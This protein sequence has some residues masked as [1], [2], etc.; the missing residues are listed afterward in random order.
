[1]SIRSRHARL[2]SKSRKRRSPSPDR[3]GQRKLLLE[4]LEERQLLAVGPRLA[5]VQ[6]NNSDLFSFDDQ[7][8]NVRDV[9]PREVALRFDENQQID[10][11][12]LGAIRVT[13]S[14]FDGVFG[15]ANDK[16]I[17]PGF[18]GVGDS[19]D[20]NEVIIRFAETLPDDVYRIEVFGAGSPTPL[21]NLRGEAFIPTLNDG[22]AD[23]TRDTIR[24]ELD[25]GPQ[26]I[27]V[28]PQPIS[29]NEQ[30]SL[31][32]ERNQIEVY[33]NNDDL[34]IESDDLGNPTPSSAENPEFYQLIF[35]R[36][37]VRNTDDVVIMPTN[38]QYDPQRDMV[39]LEYAQDLDQLLHPDT[40]ELIGPGTFRLRIG[41]DEAAPLPPLQFSP[42][43][44]VS[45]S[46]N[47]NDQVVLQ[48]TAA[49]P[50][51]N[52][53][54][55]L[56]ERHD[57][58]SAAD[59]P[60]AP[61][62]RVSV[63][64][65]SVL[66]DLNSHAGEEATAAD[67]V[68]AVNAHPEARRLI[69]AS[70][71]QGSP[72]TKVGDREVNYSPLHLDGLGSS[73][74]TATEL[75]DNTDL[76]PVIV[77]TGS[78]NAFV[79]GQFFEITDLLG[80]TRKFEFDSDVPSAL[81]D[82][83]SIPVAFDVN[84]SQ[85][86]VGAS[87]VAAINGSSFGVRAAL[88]GNR[89][90]LEGDAFVN[91]GDGVAGLAKDFQ[92]RFDS[93]PLLAISRA[94]DSFAEGQ[95]FSITDVNGVTQLFE[96]D[97]GAT[98]NVPADLA[99]TIADMQ[100]FT[101]EDGGGAAVTFELEDTL[102]G[103]GTTMPNVTIAYDSSVTT[104]QQ[105]TN[106]II[107]AIEA[108]TAA[109]NLS[110]IVPRDFG[111]GQ[112]HLGSSITSIDTSMT[113][114]FTTGAAGAQLDGAI[115][116]PFIPDGS[117][118]S[119]EIA[120][121]IAVAVSSAPFDVTALPI[122]S[123]V[124]FDNDKF[125]D[126]ALDGID[127]SLQ[128]RFD[129]G[130]V[131]TV[132]KPGSGF[133]DSDTITIRDDRG[134][135]RTF[136]FDT[137]R[138]LQVP[139]DGGTRIGDGD[140][141]AVM[142]RLAPGATPT[143]VMV[144]EFERDADGVAAGNIPIAFTSVDSQQVI[145]DAILDAIQMQLDEGRLQGITLRDAGNGRLQI[146]SSPA[147]HFDV[148]GATVLSLT[149]PI[150]NDP[151]A[152]AIT[153]T[154]TETVAEMAERIADAVNFTDFQT[155]ATVVADRIYLTNDRQVDL[156]RN[157]DAVTKTSQGIIVSSAI[158]PQP[159]D[160][161]FPGANDE[162][163][164]RDI[165]EEIGSGVEQHINTDFG[166]N[167]RDVTPGVTT[168]FYNFRDDYGVDQQGI[169]LSNAITEQQRQRAREAF[170]LW[171][172]YLGVQ[173]LESA[174]E[175]ITVVTGDLNALNPAF[176]SV[177]DFA[178][179]DFR[180][181]I[182]PRFA[183][184]L[185]V[186]DSA[187][188]WNEDFGQDW[189]LNTMVGIG[190]M[191]G[192]D[193][194]ND[195]PTSNLMARFTAPN[196]PITG[197]QSPFFNVGD[198][199]PIYPGNADILHG[200]H[201]YRPDGVDI[202]LYRFAIDLD[203]GRMGQF[204]AETFAERLPN[205]SL[206][207][208]VVRLY[209]ENPDGTRVL[210]AQNDDY[211][212]RDS[213]IEL[214]LGP[215]IYYIGVSAG[216][217]A[218][219]DPTIED[220]GIG[221]T[222]QG[223]YDL[224]LNFRSQVEDE[225]TIRDAGGLKTALDGDADGLTGGVYN[226]WFQ[227]RALNRV[228]EVTD[229]GASYRDGQILTITNAQG[230]VRRFEFDSN[231]VIAGGNIRVPF[232]ASPATSASALASTLAA[233]I[234]SVPG[235]NVTATVSPPG[236]SAIQLAGERSLSLST[237]FVGIDIQGKTIFVDKTAGPNADGSL[238][239]P[240]NNIAANGVPN[241]FAATHPGDIVR[242]VGNGGSDGNVDTLDDNFAYE[243]GFGTLPG[244]L[245]T[246]GTDMPVPKGTTVMIDPGAIFKMRRSRIGVGSSSLT[247]DRG[248]GALQVLGTPERNVIF[249]SWLD[250]SIG[251][252]NHPPTTTP[253][254]GD[255]GGLVFRAD[256]DNAESRPNL[257]DQGIFLNYVNHADIRY[258][259]GGSVVIDSI[260]QIVN[261]IQLIQTRPT[262]SYNRITE[263]ADSAMSASPNSF[264]ET[265]FHSP[266]FQSAGAF[267]S[268][269]S[270]IGPSIHS[271]TLI[272]NSTNG[273]FIRIVTPAGD[274]LR[275]LVVSGRFDD[276]DIVHVLSENLVIEGS[277][278]DPLLD[279]ER[280][281]VQLITFTPRSGGDLPAGTYS[282]KITFVDDNGFEGRPSTAST[283]FT[284]TPAA[285]LA[286]TGAIQLNQLP[287]V[288]EGFVRRRIYRTDGLSDGVYRL[289]ADVNA[290][291]TVFLD[292][293]APGDLRDVLLRD[294]PSAVDV[295]LAGQARG[296]LAKGIYNYRVVYVD[297][298][299]REGASSDPTTNISIA[300]VGSEGGV[301]LDNLPAA[302]GRFVAKRIYRSTVG[303]ISPYTLVTE[304]NATETTYVDD[305][306]S[307][308]GTLDA[309]AFGVVRA[310]PHA[311]LAIDPGTVVKLE[312]A[313]LDLRFGA[314]LI[315]EGRVGQEVIFTSRLDDEFGAGGT[316][317]TNDDDGQISGEASPG[318]GDWGGIFFGQLSR[319][320]IDN[321]LIAY[322][323][324]INRIEGT[325]T[326][327]NVI[328]VH[329]ADF[330]L[331]NSVI[332]NNAEG[333]GGQ[334]PIDRFGRGYN[335]PATI[336]VRGA[337]PVIVDNVFRD[338]NTLYDPTK[339]SESLQSPV[340]TINANSLIHDNLVDFG[341]STGPVDLITRY[342][343]NAGPLVRGN[344]LSNNA[345]NAMVI[346]G[347]VLT[348]Q[349]VW[350][351]TDIVHVL[352]NQFDQ[353]D[354]RTEDGNG[355]RTFAF[356]EVVIPEHHTFGGL[357]L[358]SSPNES[359][360][361]KLRGSGR[362]DN[363]INQIQNQVTVGTSHAN[364]Y[365][366]AG[367]TV[368]G[369]LFETDDRIGGTLH[370]IGQPGFPVVM[371]SLNDD[372]VGAGVQP[373]GQSQIDT[374]NNGLATIPRP[375]D[376]RGVRLDQNSN[377][378]NVEII[379][380]MEPPDATAPGLNA[381]TDTAQVLGDL[382]QDEQSGDENLRMGFEIQGFINE[383]ND[384]DVYSFGAVAG[385]EIWVDIDRTTYTLDTIIELLD[386]N[387][388]VLAR[389]DDTIRE[390]DEVDFVSDQISSNLIGTLQKSPSPYYP[391]HASGLPR[392]YYTVNPR[393]A[394]MRI[395]LPGN[396]GTRSTYHL[397]V[398]SKDGLTTGIYQLQV[399]S[400]EF[401]EF[402]GSTVRF[403]SISYANNGIEVIG[404]PKHSPLTGE[405]AE[406]ESAGSFASNDSFTP[407]IIIPG[408]QPQN[409]G[410]LL[411]S[412]R[413][414]ISIAGTTASAG[415]ID[416]YQFDVTY[417]AISDPSQHH[418][419]T[420]F[421]VDYADA[422]VRFNST[423][424]VF[425]AAGRLILIGRDSN[426]AEDRSGPLEG[427]DL[428]DLT[429][430]S[431][432][433]R[434]PFIGPVELPQ[435]QYFVA[436]SSNGRMPT[437]LLNNP[438]LRLEPVNSVVRIADDH[439]GTFGGS[440]AADPVN[441]VLLDPG[442]VGMGP[443]RWHVTTDRSGDPGH[444]L[445]TAFDR[446]RGGVGG[447][448]AGGSL[449][450]IEPNDSLAAAQNVDGG[451]WNTTFDPNIGDNLMNTSTTI[452]HLTINGSGDGSFDYYSFNVTGASALNPVTAIFDVDF[453]FTT[454]GPDS[455]DAELFLFDP[456]GNLIT[457]NDDAST[458][459]GAGGST[460]VLD[461]YIETLLTQSGTYVI[462]VGQFPSSAASTS[463]ITGSPLDPGQLYT[464]QISL[465][466]HGTGGGSTFNGGQS[467]Y[468]GDSTAGNTVPAG[469]TG[470]LE[471]NTFSLQGYSAE[472]LP[473]LYFN[474][475]LQNSAGA[476][477]FRVRVVDADT[478]MGPAD[479]GTLVASSNTIDA[480]SPDVQLIPQSVGSWRQL[481]LSLGEFAGQ[482]NLQ[483][484][485]EYT[486]G[487][488]GSEEGV[489]ID[490]LIIGFAERGEMVT[491]SGFTAATFST[492]PNAPGNEIHTGDYQLEIRKA[493]PFGTSVNNA[494][495][496][497]VLTDSIDTN[498]RETQATTLVVPDGSQ[499]VNGQ[500]FV[501]SDG[502]NQ[503]TFE[504]EDAEIGDGVTAGNVEIRYRTFNS[505]SGMWEYDADF[506]IA[507]R[508]RDA[509]NSAQVQTILALRAAM[510]DGEVSGTV[511]TDNRVNLF[512]TAL[513]DQPK[514]FEVIAA[515]SDANQLRDT[516]LGSGVQPVGNAT[517]VGS[518]VSAGRFEGGL[519]TI[520][521]EAGILL[522]TGD[523]RIADDPNT[524]DSSTARASQTGDA[525]L[526]NALMM[527]AA[528]D[529]RDTT[530]LEFDFQVN[531]GV[532]GDF[533][534]NFLFASEEYNEQVDTAFNDAVAILI[535]RDITDGI[536][537][538]NVALVPGP[539][540]QAPVSLS[541]V[542]NSVNSGLFN[543][544]DPSDAGRF[545]DRFAYDGFTEVFTAELSGA[546][547]LGPG[548][549][550]IKIV[551]SDVADLS[552]DSAIFVEAG[553]MATSAFVRP[554]EGIP[555]IRHQGQG[556][557]NRFR[558]QG[559]VII[560]S[561]TIA[562]SKTFGVVA[563]AGQR[564]TDGTFSASTAS[565]PVRLQ[566][567]DPGPVR[568]LVIQNNTPL[569]GGFAPGVTIANNTIF[570]DGSLGGIHVSGNGQTYELTTRRSWETA[571]S[572]TA[573]DSVCD[574]D[575][576]RITAFG[577]VVEFEF[578]DVAG[579]P[580]DD[581]NRA[582]RVGSGTNGG[583]GWAEGRVPVYFRRTVPNVAGY[584]QLEMA[585]AI[586]NAIDGSRLVSND[587]RLSINTY[588]APS[589]G[590]GGINIRGLDFQ[591]P[592]TETDWAVYV[593]S[594]T[595]VVGNTGSESVT[596]GKGLH[597][598]RQVGH[599]N[600]PQP[601]ARV[602]NNTIFGDDGSFA[603]FPDPNVEPNDTLFNAIETR[604][605]RQHNPVSYTTTAT[606]G[607]SQNFLGDTS[608]D[609][610][611]YQFQLDIGD[612]VEID[613]NPSI[614]GSQL[615]P[616]MRLFNSVGEELLISTSPPASPQTVN[617]TATAGGTY[618]VAVSGAGNETYSS[619]SLASR[620]G[621]ASTGDYSLSVNV[622][623]P[624]TYVIQ[625]Q[626]GSTLSGTV[627]LEI[628]DVNGTI[629][630]AT[631]NI[632]GGDRFPAVANSIAN[633]I[634][635]ATGGTNVQNLPNGAFGTANPLQRIE[636]EVYGDAS[637]VFHNTRQ[638]LLNNAFLVPDHE[639]FVVIR[640]AARVTSLNSALRITPIAD[641]DL[642]QI[643]VERGILVSNEAT[644]TLLNNVLANLHIGVEQALFQPG[645]PGPVDA[646]RSVPGGMVEGASLY[647]ANDPNPVSRTGAGIPRNSNIPFSGQDFQV[648]LA[649]NL[650]L[651]ENAPDH[652]FFPAPFS[653]VID[654]SIDSLPERDEFE[655]IKEAIGISLSPILAPDRD[656][657]GQLRVDDPEV[658][659]PSGQGANVFKDRGSLDRSDFVGPAAVL[660]VPQDND[661]NGFD[662]DDAVSF[663]QI[664]DR[665]QVFFNFTLQ[666]VDGFE[667][668]DPFPG[669]GVNDDTLDGRILNISDD[670]IPL[671]VRGP[672]ITVFRD[673]VS[674]K[675]GIDYTFRYNRTSNEAVL[676]P[677]AGIWS[678]GV[679]VIRVNNRDQFVVD[680]G[681]GSEVA[682][683]DT[684]T[685]TNDNGEAATFEFESGYTMTVAETLG[686]RVPDLGAAPGGIAD[687]QRFTISE[688]SGRNIVT[689]EFDRNGNV[690]LG[691]RPI[692]FAPNASANEIAN[693][694]V[695]ALQNA[696][697]N[698][699]GLPPT[700]QPGQLN[701]VLAARNLGGGLVHLGAT[702][703][704][705][706][707]TSFSALVPTVAQFPEALLV[708]AAGGMNIT[709][710]DNFTIS[711]GAL[712]VTF[713]FDDNQVGGG[714]ATGAV[715]ITFGRNNSQDVIANLISQA[716]INDPT[717]QQL[718]L[719]P[720]YAG[721]GVL[722]LGNSDPTYTLNVINAPRFDRAMFIGGVS[723]GED[724]T[725]DFTR[726]DGLT[727]S[728]TFEF[729]SNTPPQLEDVNNTR[730]AFTAADT[731]LDLADKIVTA[732]RSANVS[733]LPTHS[734]DGIIAIGGTDGHRIT[735]IFAPSLQLSGTPGVQ[736]STTLELPVTPAIEVPANGGLGVAD[737]ETFLLDDGVNFRVFE[738][739][740]NNSV[741][742]GNRAISFAT[743][744]NQDMV[745][746]AMVASIN[747]SG[748][749]YAPRNVGMGIVELN[750][751]AFHTIL[752]PSDSSLQRADILNMTSA[753]DGDTFTI[754]DGTQTVTFEFE[755]ASQGN[756]V[757]GSNEPILFTPSAPG[758]PGADLDALV[759]TI[760]AV[761]RNAG[762]N[763]MPANRGNGR[764]EL[765]DT[766]AYRV[767]TS[768]SA[769]TTV[770]VPGGGNPIVF[771]ANHSDDRVAASIVDAINAANALGTFD[772]V[773][774]QVRGGSTLFVNIA[775]QN[776]ATD[777]AAVAGIPNFFLSAVKDLPGN[778]LKANQST[779]ETQFTI[780]L[781]GTRLDFG[782]APDPF[783]GAGRYPT[784]FANNGARHVI[785]DNPL[786]LGSG[787]DADDD[788][789]PAAN[790]DGDD[791]D[792]RVE[793]SDSTI[794][795]TSQAPYS[796]QVPSTGGA[797]FTEGETFTILS[798][799]GEEATFEFDLAGNGA[800]GTNVPIVISAGD[801]PAAVAQAVVDAV[802]SRT[803]LVLQAASLGGGLVSL[804]G[805]S[806]HRI[807]TSR[808]LLVKEGFPVET[809]RVPAVEATGTANVR[810]G[811]MVEF[812][813]GRA[814]RTFEFD[815][816][817][818]IT[819][820]NIAVPFLPVDSPA[821]VADALVAAV[822]SSGLFFDPTT[823]LA[824]GN[825][826]LISQG[827]GLI[828]IDGPESHA[829]DLAGS[830]LMPAGRVPVELATPG[831]GLAIEV[832]G[833]LNVG[834]T[835]ILDDGINPAVTFEFTLT[836]TVG[837]SNRPVLAGDLANADQVANAIV[838]AIK[839][840]VT[841]GELTAIEPVNLSGGIVDVAGSAGLTLDLAG[842]ANLDQTGDAGGIADGQSMVVS[843]GAQTVIF[844]FDRNGAVGFG[845]E[846][847]LFQ[848]SDSPVSL[849]TAI[850][851]AIRATSLEVTVGDLGAGVLQVQ[852]DDDDG[853]EFRGI[854][855]PGA[856]STVV[857]TASGDGFL[858]GWFD[859]NQDG[860]W[861]DPNERVF[862][863]QPVVA[864][865]NFLSV[866]V[867]ALFPAPSTLPL[868]LTFARFR[869]STETG[870]SP[871]GLAVDG[872]VEDY[873][874][875]VVTNDAPTTAVPPNPPAGSCLVLPNGQ[876]GIPDCV[877]D[878][879]AD[880]QSFDLRAFF[881]DDDLGD[882]LSFQVLS[883]LEVTGNGSAVVD[884]SRLT[885]TSIERSET[886]EFDNDGSTQ[887]GTNP[888]VFKSHLTMQVPAAGFGPGGVMDGDLITVQNG[889]TDFV[890][891]FDNNLLAANGIPIPITTN[892]SQND[893]AN[894]I[895]AA[896][897]T[898]NTG[899]TPVNVG[900]GLVQLQFPTPVHDVTT[901]SAALTTGSQPLTNGQLVS[902][903]LD[904]INGEN[905]GVAAAVDPTNATRIVLTGDR[906]VVESTGPDGVS[907]I[908]QPHRLQTSLGPDGRTLTLEFLE[909]QNGTAEIT[910]R[911]TDRG[912][913]FVDSTFTVTMTPV[914]DPPTA[915]SV[916]LPPINEVTT[917]DV[918]LG[919]ATPTP[920]S[921][922]PLWDD[923]DP[924]PNEQQV[925]M[926]EILDD[927][928]VHGT[929]VEAADFAT[930][931]NFTYLPTA[932]FNTAAGRTA[933]L[934][935]RVTDS[936]APG[937]DTGEPRN[938][939][940]NPATLTFQITPV[941]APPVGDAQSLPAMGQ[942]ALEDQPVLIT[943][944]GHDGDPQPE[945]VQ[946][947]TFFIATQPPNGTLTMT[948]NGQYTYQ[949]DA[950]FNGQDAFTFTVLDEFNSSSVPATVTIDLT[951]VNDSPTAANFNIA[952][953]EFSSYDSRTAGNSPLQGNDGDPEVV[954]TLM[955]NIVT[956]PAN[957]T[958]SMLDLAAGH[959][960]Y[961]PNPN[962]NGPDSFTYNVV[963]DASAGAPA[964]LTSNTATVAINVRPTNQAPIATPQ[965]VNVD[966]DNSVTITLTGDDGD[967]GAVQM[968][969]FAIAPA[970]LGGACGTFHTGGSLSTT[971]GV[972]TGFDPATGTLSYQPNMNF[973]GVDEF[974]FQVTDDAQA[975][976]PAFLTSAPATVTVN[977][978]P[979]NDA[980]IALP[981]FPASPVQVT[982]D[983]AVTITLLGDD[984]GDGDLGTSENQ[985]LTFIPVELPD[986]GTLMF[987]GGGQ[988]EYTPDPDATGPDSFTYIVR[989]DDSAG[990]PALSSQVATVSLN[991]TPVNDVP[992]F[993]GG[994][995]VTVN[996]DPGAQSI[997][998]WATGIRPGPST[999]VDEQGQSVA[1000]SVEPLQL[1001]SPFAS[1002]FAVPP[1003]IAPNGTLTFTPAPH[1004][1005][1006]E[1007]VFRTT[1008]T[1009]SANG[1010]TT[1011]QT[1012]TIRVN[1013]VNDAPQ[1014][1015]LPSLFAAVNEDAGPVVF[1016]NWA[1017]NRFPGPQAAV[1018]EIASQSLTQFN[1019]SFTTTG[1020][1021][1022]FVAPPAIDPTS[1023][1024]LTFQTAPHTNGQA[1025]VR[1026]SLTDTGSSTPPNVNTS[1027][1028]QTF[1029][1030]TVN[1031]MNDPPQFTATDVTASEDAG[1032]VT[1033]PGWAS[1034]ILAGP[1035]TATDEST[1036][1037]VSFQTTVVNPIGQLPIL[1038]FGSAS[1039]D[1040]N[1041]GNLMFRTLPDRNGEAMI[1042]VRASDN[1043]NPPAS[1044]AVRT[1045]TVTIQ[1046]VNDPPQ[1047]AASNQTVAE[1048]AGL[1049][1050]VSGFVCLTTTGGCEVRPGP[1051]S[1052]VDEVNQQ[1053]TFEATNDNNALFAIQPMITAQGAL[1054]YQPAANASGRAVVVL[1055]GTDNGNPEA[1056][1057]SQTFTITVTAQ[1058]DA[1059][1060]LTL[1061]GTQS[1062]VED[1063]MLIVPGL[1064]VGDVDAD[1065]IDVI[1066]RVNS[1067][1068]LTMDTSV[1069]GGVVAGNVTNNN[1070]ATLTVRAAPAA[1071]SATLAA[1072][1073]LRY[1074]G[1075][1076]NF[1077]GQD[1078]LTMIVDDL[1079][1080][1081]GAPGPLTATG[1082]IS[1083]NVTSFNDAPF[1084]ANPI[1085]D[1086]DAAEDDPP[1087]TIELFPNV[1088]NDPD[1089]ATNNDRLSVTV[1090]SVVEGP[1091]SDPNFVSAVIQP[1092]ATTLQL[1093]FAPN[1094]V[1095]TAEIT[1096]RATDVE[1097]L[1098]ATDSF[1099]L[1100]VNP[1101]NDPPVAVNDEASI[1102]RGEVAVIDVPANDTD[1103]DGFVD[1104]TTVQIVSGPNNANAQVNPT[1105]GAITVTPTANFSGTVTLRY[1106]IVDNEG[1107]MS[1108]EATVTVRV[1109]APPVANDDT[1110]ETD[1111]GTPIDIPV[1112]AN[1113][1114]DPDGTIDRTS[1115]TI[1116]NLSTNGDVDIDG[1117]T[1118]VVT[1119]TPDPSFS[1120]V[1121]TFRY[1122]FLD[1123][1124]GVPS[1125]EATVTVTVNA[1126]MHWKNPN[1127]ALDVNADG[1128]VTPLDVLLIINELNKTG[1129]RVLPVP[1130]PGN[1131]PPPF[1132]D[1133]NC[1134][1135]SLTS[1136]DALVI[1137]NH[1138]NS[1139]VFQG[1140]EGEGVGPAESITI[1141][1142]GQA[1143]GDRFA[1144]TAAP[1145]FF[1146]Y[1147]LP[1148]GD[1149]QAARL[1150][1151][1152]G[1153]A[1154]HATADLNNSID[1155]VLVD[1156]DDAFVRSSRASAA[1157]IPAS[1158]ASA[1159]VESLLDDIAGDLAQRMLGDDPLD[1160]EPW[1161]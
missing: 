381:T 1099:F 930:S 752:L 1085:A 1106:T 551:I 955:Y 538:Q 670:G 492:N 629:R 17:T 1083:L 416:F 546:E 461:S 469:S 999:A 1064:A 67:V 835:F 798:F 1022:Q 57:L 686:M 66:I 960:V 942:S 570:S 862:A 190:A 621:P 992:E 126:V 64:E 1124:D 487:G 97:A 542:N 399:R 176:P 993:T 23:A 846:T 900:G 29:R 36:D 558:D 724:F 396:A 119:N 675:E 535:D 27:A 660:V 13:Q 514:T 51:E 911:A 1028:T 1036:Q 996:E 257:E 634:N 859:W 284:I 184:S 482:D 749:V 500:T 1007:A 1048:D 906:E 750:P 203:Q 210:M 375:N 206:L 756:G 885:I 1093:N 157:L 691:N 1073:G 771:R 107:A 268:D 318:P 1046:P 98:L 114:L 537:Y 185:L 909:D 1158:A 719:S 1068:R 931:G 483:L 172:N 316:F 433:P 625:A 543:N 998:G 358:Q 319:G 825:A 20:E 120:R 818:A 641:N 1044:A 877:V 976:N 292:D 192:L 398:R 355:R 1035:D 285:A 474:Y 477:S 770:G 802:N 1118:G 95:T 56:V 137:S 654:S 451:P 968:L 946:L 485:F 923:G 1011:P 708:P 694:I 823:A 553:S 952:V 1096:V 1086:I 513:V 1027:P 298:Q 808:S 922:L 496:G 127:V 1100:T 71:N 373:D 432:G 901:T 171:G 344:Q 762:L 117:F 831:A 331:T 665:S 382:A 797:A 39:L 716:L 99:A 1144:F 895:V 144:F 439:I 291:D 465:Q 667:G 272:N 7:A 58:G 497:L 902:L 357:R 602:V 411:A 586:E 618:Y 191:L 681:A 1107:A 340:I 1155:R 913:Q 894:A 652:N 830:T 46:F 715:P 791:A 289:V 883:V 68:A 456:A 544:N 278:G 369:Q 493:T 337:Q 888:V 4:R 624:R 2:V 139:A 745:A 899:V 561:N 582:C 348:T 367:F 213:F 177:L 343:D 504:Y 1057:S 1121:D 916:T 463:G 567:P 345:T 709:D 764:V 919:I 26:V 603:F 1020:N 1154:S 1056:S 230:T 193:L 103:D 150:L 956:P 759:D 239:R 495:V 631:V 164:H 1160:G 81:N 939:P 1061:P 464:L 912:R 989:D 156:S 8:E 441:P 359:L 392:D 1014:F 225:N 777:F 143:Q 247:V 870:L 837:G 253:S 812:H 352:T 875:Q 195:L 1072:G 532:G 402:P 72:L 376:W 315:A 32:Q 166:A 997:A 1077:N 700:Q 401:D 725:I 224:R 35:T 259:G 657:T 874:V 807:D 540:P 458:L 780:V 180:V 256:V 395:A 985:I 758:T 607:D 1075:N 987:M 884:A 805:Q 676:T 970:M 606:I 1087:V 125:L 10:P 824:T 349:S 134:V 683:G 630:T 592:T 209:R 346:R 961:T 430:G 183:D 746:D 882:L 890:F 43:L 661:A 1095:G 65:S 93:G 898:Q 16:V 37:S 767:N 404:L 983:M 855:T 422:L 727:T 424:S 436:V 1159:E 761:I 1053:V 927:S 270:R 757:S 781:P 608:V 843:D 967:S 766:A 154:G 821:T 803:E 737:G 149:G 740:A 953:D 91:L 786:H 70:I 394:G 450:E 313:R 633:A 872:E 296:S 735:T 435:G 826:R 242:I 1145:G 5:G 415:D 988:V 697:Q 42:S 576:F 613:I 438:L 734:G 255:W 519:Q 412:D 80:M 187:V 295:T 135:V 428:D 585:R 426:I 668:S 1102:P 969:T 763:L 249:T 829:V 168:V 555:S 705:L 169:P 342:A 220:T 853:V 806:L 975:G 1047:F 869:L 85:A 858:S 403:A 261:P 742:P 851:A 568:N 198:P 1031:P 554:P 617:L 14:G 917:N 204:T 229:D 1150:A 864:G 1084:V 83:A 486:E 311:R 892:T 671:Q 1156:V 110:G 957:G 275:P 943:L 86:Q 552:A 638:R 199:E 867:P 324:G 223:V 623:A 526:E 982:E 74:D 9:S 1149:A 926:F 1040:P 1142:H 1065:E 208:T 828:Y 132:T 1112:L 459:S 893:V 622:R 562:D 301:V 207:D 515:N 28:V 215:G 33:F 738:F 896:I 510:S 994:P 524:D 108:E 1120:G 40:G 339:S 1049:T 498:D 258:G 317:D 701:T 1080:N 55:V 878:E 511:S 789:N 279:L 915:Q 816:D 62:V 490:D 1062:V 528:G 162:P 760:V 728:V 673:G 170:Q 89:V 545:L 491:N 163:G 784:L 480:N 283:D 252:D 188:Q 827:G 682:D 118:S 111:S 79:D 785:S 328:E 1034:N 702:P 419:A 505:I 741:R 489:Y 54:T 866:N 365:E 53:I 15:N 651:F 320:S 205:A 666:F 721:D 796:L 194:A 413:A 860:D 354:T 406:D 276:T 59:S 548:T 479:L 1006:G 452:P 1029:T 366:G 518:D 1058:N 427:S 507:R 1143:E 928:N 595:S 549:H 1129:P 370:V 648:D 476:D 611:F 443:N 605:G 509:I 964:G 1081:E 145:L 1114:S 743:T 817:G 148:S 217:N 309:S 1042:T 475:F 732:I 232:T 769:L 596:N 847:I 494:A 792:F 779:D 453:G 325:F 364:A 588:V 1133:A 1134:D 434:D 11:A 990:G 90:V 290:S 951:P 768:N 815:N 201:L 774:A 82:P 1113:D 384:I 1148:R 971:N 380:E 684:F 76:G 391:S 814:A 265:N 378:R 116:V 227:T 87:V 251:L 978:M 593:E 361:I 1021:L 645:S 744:D 557:Q 857:V 503:V 958:L 238:A 650:P 323:G 945:E 104:Q 959:F 541:T 241:A 277:A 736:P 12:T 69:V 31:V 243:I 124:R 181:R 216:G 214:D 1067:G 679:Y 522:T 539:S 914:N 102:I 472:D 312:G 368:G 690:Q 685:I 1109:A 664:D 991:I 471:S 981:S 159:F 778:T 550:R 598:I 269:Y 932:D 733:L 1137:V 470:T 189:F 647:H 92:D 849:A 936:D 979:V 934:V 614:N 1079:G 1128:Q 1063:A 795:L 1139:V 790:A 481:R 879:D 1146:E 801:T 88:A 649:G 523:A 1152:A 1038:Q 948:G 639:Q 688:S 264:D 468:F 1103:V 720:F 891:E 175:G 356:D 462:G 129:A 1105:S 628:E 226:F 1074:V 793:V 322:G 105:L 980:P 703:D 75:T 281:A 78:G 819:P 47:T 448:G 245:L 677:L 147:F 362:D 222:S 730:I 288:T 1147:R 1078:L 565:V 1090:V 1138:L 115:A 612:T 1055:T 153:R 782:D 444:G 520:G 1060:T 212:S 531:S 106:S 347:E 457:F 908:N 1039:V 905:F 112:I 1033:I 723:D 3:D 525:D 1104:R 300:G 1023:G 400:K 907:V 714:V 637:H 938:Q 94:G 1088:F 1135:G 589:R 488:A 136:E 712:S 754:T 594:V 739:D 1098:S 274:F 389:S 160:L 121:S 699:P 704:I 219:Y 1026:V 299:G 643:V 861:I 73:F 508:I 601:F 1066:F 842:A 329:Q 529:T 473:T 267:T 1059:P 610:D 731:H 1141:G 886:F 887:P 186:M 499:V 393:D 1115:V 925:P 986:K 25:L 231:N 330:R 833:P 182:D 1069:A 710:G 765:N 1140:G 949:P 286:G 583:N 407:S 772:G 282:Y 113:G 158:N 307:A 133:D 335:R 1024:Q 297:A 820:G 423:I 1051:L 889:S 918:N 1082:S 844:E 383:P 692:P 454:G 1136:N 379:L 840:A 130:P 689:F 1:M 333:V 1052:A 662:V 351:D 409:V 336:F 350:D 794:V 421:D 294:P 1127:N 813:D 910:V 873:R 1054:Q 1001:T 6:P 804:G 244:Q 414:A 405:S 1131:E 302:N 466:N 52:A 966:E 123:E 560:H 848:A 658:D 841:A 41:T 1151:S 933:T 871:V 581:V 410:N 293:V 50:G 334:G 669:V 420:T 425:D 100:T 1018:D 1010:A 1119:Y 1043:G 832:A 636:A 854:F 408:D 140:V 84:T 1132:Y 131:L 385:T 962:Y 353:R 417:E 753:N 338:N 266:Q 517:F 240:F 1157:S 437:E 467:F 1110:A 776:A 580:T 174:R 984:D 868:G 717:A 431:V 800:A 809:L 271:N 674:L 627:V 695:T 314:Q 341:R 109:G 579:S 787:V 38:V 501:V 1005:N 575:W 1012:F 950:N 1123:N 233:A 973:N 446:S 619:L 371:T 18:I 747:G 1091:Q 783:T 693:A 635:G 687:G 646:N 1094:A 155:T 262:I 246:D 811:D 722:T 775:D 49:R 696:N 260:Q 221:G 30:G 1016:P 236:S 845:N 141:V 1003:A 1108:N 663:I 1117:L 1153:E 1101:E 1111:A 944:T 506:Q 442:F 626:H 856:T 564:I 1008:L 250:E 1122:R 48:F 1070:S 455:V 755:D 512:G 24:F 418:F 1013:A 388:N 1030:I 152:I 374:N 1092:G 530:Y 263:S 881:A 880:N 211:F 151:A 19:P 273:L 1032:L 822:A 834:D 142:H 1017:T 566:S 534:L 44:T 1041:T 620:T 1125:N 377:D 632:G 556:D 304:L 577:E 332:E 599:D 839:A 659:T 321:A 571:P 644:P 237:S 904:A 280:P 995:N 1004:A 1076:T 235:F 929:I 101:I 167:G 924:L 484:I 516:I 713:E 45:S 751:P 202:D 640:N 656:V 327:F 698:V 536:T 502:V 947:L 61:R 609:V 672:A 655:S 587:S 547:A 584:S 616:V 963:D 590:P 578:E 903:L 440:T 363:H 386:A 726:T 1000:F 678:E 569:A 1089:I 954:Q 940:S 77:V 974:C 642:D 1009:D 1097:G 965:A 234:N 977:V 533:F 1161:V 196:D 897:S 711:S 310:R 972:I 1025:T 1126:V 326:G 1116:T 63:V 478:R 447:P 460:S 615:S 306:F 937:Q 372:T 559:Q 287:P 876:P 1071:I 773:T 360:V 729:D 941:N 218:D 445:T 228:L 303:G 22:D 21:R 935:Y 600:A 173:F 161:D 810:D 128:G 799:T 604:Q 200:Q 850:A 146:G 863:D 852:G 248:G 707:N 597:R 574:G 96:F 387:G 254:R 1019:V 591:I 680:A 573:G 138:F 122:S 397:Q 34:F 563:D 165:P 572:P 920:F 706:L 449:L 836:G 748:L 305:G 197:K 838:T 308:G 1045:F 429:R 718:G 527:L 653:M 921:L 60:P 788:G 178:A 521:M 1015:Q 1037:I 1050:T 1130:T 390:I 865:E 179:N 1002:L